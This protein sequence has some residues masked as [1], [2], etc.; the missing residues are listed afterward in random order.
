MAE[1][2]AVALFNDPTRQGGVESFNRVLK[3]FYPQNLRFIIFNL[4][5]ETES[6]YRVNDII[7]VGSLNFIF[8]IIN[9]ILK[10]KLRN[11]LLIKKVREIK[12]DFLIFSS[13]YEINV[14]H[15]IEAKKIFVQHTSL[16]EYKKSYLY[17]K[18]N[19]KL[20][21]EIP[22]YFIFLS[23]Y[24]KEIFCKGLN[25]NKE[26]VRIIRHSSETELLRTEKQKNKKLI[27]VARIDNI[28][29]RFDLAINTMKKLPDYTLDIYGDGPD[30]ENCKKII[31]ERELNNVFLKGSTNKVQEKLDK[32]GI[33]V[34]TSDYEGYPISTIEAMRR[35]LPIVLRNTFNSAQDIV[36][37]NGILLEKQWDEDKFIEA[38]KKVYDNYEYYSENSKKLG[39]RH[40]PEVIKKE[41]D[42]LFKGE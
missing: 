41:W 33:F 1:I 4:K 13:P 25:L 10:N 14:L 8:R 42:R 11:F 6:L 17:N 12:P 3:S 31:K 9:K 16:E 23:P 32:A 2:L 39:E 28:S 5:K 7:K 30:I 38:V 19:E 24:D 21:R 20:L 37:D 34:M 29:K 18:E 36:I 40:S 35:G 22:D 26:K 15:K 27:M